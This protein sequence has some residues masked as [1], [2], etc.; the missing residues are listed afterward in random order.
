[1]KTLALG[2]LLFTGVGCIH[3]QPIGPLADRSA[4]G[5]VPAPGMARDAAGGPALPTAPPPTPPAML[6]SPAEVTDANSQQ[7]ARRLTEEMEADRKGIEAMPRYAEVSVI[8]GK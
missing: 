8:R 7:A 4:G 1:M 5:P 6:V 2:L 3:F